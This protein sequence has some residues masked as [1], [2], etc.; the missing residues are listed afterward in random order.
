MII[1]QAMIFNY[2]LT[3]YIYFSSV[4]GLIFFPTEW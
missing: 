1:E 4:K 3:K 2:D